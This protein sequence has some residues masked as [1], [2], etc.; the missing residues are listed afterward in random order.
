MILSA[1]QPAYLPWLGYFDKIVRSDLFV[2]LDSVQFEKNS[3]T[4]RNQIKTAQAPIWLTVPVK[5]KGHM[6]SSLR[7]MEID[8]RQDWKIRHLKA[9]FFNYKKAPRFDECYP[10]LERLYKKDHSLLADLCWDH[11][12]FWL[13]EFDIK[14]RIVRSSELD[15]VSK[16]SDL[17]FEL[18]H[19]YEAT[20]YISG[21]LGRSYLEEDKFIQA[22]IDIEYQDYQ[23]P[24]YPQLWGEFLPNMSIVDFWMNTDRYELAFGR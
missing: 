12:I 23:H 20:K 2:F 11:L 22:G 18:C 5:I 8:N 13:Q 19:F 6:T 15:I 14:T 16:K 3:F 17:I 24:Q 10:V 9:I 4:N 7:D 1:H 21:A